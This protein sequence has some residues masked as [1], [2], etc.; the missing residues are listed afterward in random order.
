MTDDLIARLRD[1]EYYGYDICKEAADAL[2]AQ[3]RELDAKC[4]ECSDL[5]IELAKW[6]N[7][8]RD[9]DNKALQARIAELGAALNPIMKISLLHVRPEVASAIR[10]ARAALENKND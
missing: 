1:A 3:A 7:Y 8:W 4:K 2:E 5:K 10:A 9:K 6:V